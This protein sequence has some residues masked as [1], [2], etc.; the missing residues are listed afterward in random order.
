MRR[1]RSDRTTS[2]YVGIQRSGTACLSM[3]LMR[4]GKRLAASGFPAILGLTAAF[5]LSAG[6][7]SA[8][9]RRSDSPKLL[10]MAGLF[11]VRP[12]FMALEPPAA[13]T[14]FAYILGPHRRLRAYGHQ[15]AGIHWTTWTRREARG[16]GTMYF[17]QCN[18]TCY[19]NNFARYTLTLRASR[20]RAGRYTRLLLTYRW[21]GHTR[22]LPLRLGVQRAGT[23]RFYNWLWP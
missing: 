13:N 5:I 23:V 21:P 3:R 4:L 12:G 15:G 2:T 18:P 14:T 7:A 17:N 20:V 22:Q 8:D 16:I 6:A 19:A 1:P 11:A 10:E 9:A